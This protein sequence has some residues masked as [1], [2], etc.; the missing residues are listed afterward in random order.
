MAEN[1]TYFVKDINLYF[2][3]THQISISI[4]PR[5][6]MPAHVINK[7]LKTEDKENNL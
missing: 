2:S 7:L 5:K 1:F 6:S 3:R 4:N